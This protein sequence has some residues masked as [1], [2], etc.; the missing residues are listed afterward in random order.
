[1]VD[2]TAVDLLPQT[3][4]FEVVVHLYSLVHNHRLRVKIVLEE[5]KAEIDS[6]TPLWVAADWYE[7]ECHEMYG[8]RFK[9]HPNLAPLLLYEGFEGYPLRKDYD[10][11]LAQPLVDLRPV[12]ERHDYGEHYQPVKG[13]K[14]SLPS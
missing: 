11:G 13:N 10:K 5:A 3:P 12:R 4:R 6:I 7:R 1:M 8:I 2:L 14:P 9:G